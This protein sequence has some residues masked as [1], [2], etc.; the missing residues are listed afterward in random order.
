MLTRRRFLLSSA[1]L[2]AITAR[3]RAHAEAQPVKASPA[4]S[5]P[6][7]VA[8]ANGIVAV[9]RAVELLQKGADPL[10]AAI[11]GV[12]IVEDDP[13]DMTVGYGAVP[14]EEGVVQLDASV[15]HGPTSSAG[16]VASLEGV[17]NPSKV[18]KLVF[19]HTD[20]VLL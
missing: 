6:V 9:A 17:K 12:N 7:A 4:G 8:S 10:D 18:A 2:A 19:E 15:Y 16:A 14:N 1:A 11:A 5:R 3:T 13:N 20:H